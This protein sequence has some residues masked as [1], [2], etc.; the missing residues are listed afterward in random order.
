MENISSFSAL[1]PRTECWPQAGAECSGFFIAVIYT[2][3]EVSLPSLAP[4]TSSRYSE[5]IKLSQDG[6]NQAVVSHFDSEL[7]PAPPHLPVPASRSASERRHLGVWVW[8]HFRI[9]EALIFMKSWEKCVPTLCFDLYV[10]YVG[11]KYWHRQPDFPK[12]TK[13]LL[14]KIEAN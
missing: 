5:Y 11:L 12:E 2:R 14:K 13:T 10:R 1:S 9:G 6:G 4:L 3:A 8:H 7:P